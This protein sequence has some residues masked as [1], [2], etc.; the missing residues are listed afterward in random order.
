[1]KSPQQVWEEAYPDRRKWEALDQDTRD[2][3]TRVV[4]VAQSD[5]ARTIDALKE[6]LRD[7]CFYASPTS[8]MYDRNGFSLM[9]DEDTAILAI[10]YRNAPL[11]ATFDEALEAAIKHYTP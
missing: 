1:M 11:H 4:R 2:E 3:W 6:I 9:V 7:R 5:A 10:N 8:K